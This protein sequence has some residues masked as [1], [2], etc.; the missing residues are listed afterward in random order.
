MRPYSLPLAAVSMLVAFV[1]L[2]PTFAR[3]ESDNFYTFEYDEN[4]AYDQNSRRY[5]TNDG[6][7]TNFSSEL[8]PLLPD[9]DGRVYLRDETV[10]SQGTGQRLDDGSTSLQI[11]FKF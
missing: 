3:A 4:R 1:W 11:D 6:Y 9:T 10:R 7:I 8:F 2:L 5:N